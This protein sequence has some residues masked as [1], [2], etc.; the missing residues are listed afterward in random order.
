M[1]VNIQIG[2]GKKFVHLICSGKYTKLS[3]LVKIWESAFD[4]AKKEGLKSVLM[5]IREIEGPPP[6]MHQRYELGVLASQ[7]RLNNPSSICISLLGKEPY[8]S[9]DRYAETV[10]R[11]R[12]VPGRVFTDFSEA[13]QWIEN[14]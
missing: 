8:I 4:I 11:N 1:P 7:Y 3:E 14:Y 13:V 5:D 2:L 10:A 12:G 9:P 6:T